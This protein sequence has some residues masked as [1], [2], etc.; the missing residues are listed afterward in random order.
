[1]NEMTIFEI[2]ITET[3]D[4]LCYEGRFNMI[5]ENESDLCHYLKIK[6]SN[7]NITE[8]IDGK[9]ME[10]LLYINEDKKEIEFYNFDNG[11]SLQFEYIEFSEIAHDYGYNKIITEKLKYLI[12][13]NNNLNKRL[14][15]ISNRI[16]D[17]AIF[18]NNELA[19]ID[20]KIDF[21]QKNNDKENLSKNIGKKEMLEKVLA[22]VNGIQHRR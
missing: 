9:L 11:D 8:K 20:K 12:R 10:Y 5:H 3:I 22:R 16:N 21:Y 2:K 14:L 18:N 19:K 4:I 6:P 15:E 17:V 1:M 7:K 13:E